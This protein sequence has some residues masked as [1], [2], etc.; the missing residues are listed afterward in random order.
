MKPNAY[1]YLVIFRI[2]SCYYILSILYGVHL[3]KESPLKSFFVKVSEVS[4]ARHFKNTRLGLGPRPTHRN[5]TTAVFLMES[6]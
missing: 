6:T 4:T 5:T 3:C 2:N 1:Q